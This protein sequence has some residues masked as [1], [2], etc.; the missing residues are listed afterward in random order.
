MT[1]DK[2]L[3]PISHHRQSAQVTK[4]RFMS[5]DSLQPVSLLLFL[6]FSVELVF[7]DTLKH[8]HDWEEKEE[9]I[10]ETVPADKLLLFTTFSN[11]MNQ[12]TG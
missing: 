5:R 11:K 4:L 2:W 6:L 12:N 3:F 8:P 7:S 1:E 10:Y 9:D